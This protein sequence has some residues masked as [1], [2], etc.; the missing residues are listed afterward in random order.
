MLKI[1]F[2][3]LHRTHGSPLL[4]CWLPCIAFIP[5]SSSCLFEKFEKAIRKHPDGFDPGGIPEVSRSPPTYFFDTQNLIGP[6]R[7]TFHLRPEYPGALPLFAR[8]GWV[9]WGAA[10]SVG[11]LSALE[12]AIHWH[13]L[14]VSRQCPDSVPTVSP[15]SRWPL[16][17][18]TLAPELRGM[19]TGPGEGRG[20]ALGP[21][22][23][24]PQASGRVRCRG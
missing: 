8:H 9:L 14:G 17:A 5:R 11:A 4:L 22:K 18:S 23:G 20:H 12:K 10:R 2:K 3:K 21:R 24:Q 19:P 15:P 7:R 1:T 6:G 13:V 16:A